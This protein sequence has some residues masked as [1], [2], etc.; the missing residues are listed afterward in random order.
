MLSLTRKIAWNRAL[1]SSPLTPTLSPEYR[2]EGA[3]EN[4]KTKPPANWPF[5]GGSVH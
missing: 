3:S 2:G 5:A 1:A 4:A